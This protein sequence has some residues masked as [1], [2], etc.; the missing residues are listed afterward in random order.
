MDI[1]KDSFFSPIISDLIQYL[2]ND[3]F[4]ASLA[5]KREGQEKYISSPVT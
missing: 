3:I 1:I 5:N 2:F 4:I